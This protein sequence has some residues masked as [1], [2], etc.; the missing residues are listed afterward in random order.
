MRPY[1]TKN[2]IQN[3]KTTHLSCKFEDDSYVNSLLHFKGLGPAAC[4]RELMDTSDRFVSG[5]P[6][7]RSHTYLIFQP[8]ALR[9]A[10]GI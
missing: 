6:V 2:K 10:R 3:G 9:P 5:K 8:T 4:P 1:Y 7:G